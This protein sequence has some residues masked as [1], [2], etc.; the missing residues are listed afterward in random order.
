[1]T[2]VVDRWERPMVVPEAETKIKTMD[3]EV[4]NML[5][6]WLTKTDARKRQ[7]MYVSTVSDVA[8]Q[9]AV[10]LLKVKRSVFH[11][12]SWA[13]IV[14]NSAR[15]TLARMVEERT[16]RLITERDAQEFL[17]ST[18]IPG[19]VFFP[20]TYQMKDREELPLCVEE[21]MA[22]LSYRERAII[23]LRFG[24][25]D[26]WSYSLGDVA[27][28]F[29]VTRERIRQLEARA[30]RKLQCRTGSRLDRVL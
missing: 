14:C 6:W 1:M 25:G 9:T 28:I 5:L 23:E 10:N 3:P 8:Q 12:V 29:K 20:Q 2:V 17:S 24:L 27:D 30:I 18:G 15:W 4:R 13:T 22:K 11:S 16:R 19:D 26:G 21:A 7:C